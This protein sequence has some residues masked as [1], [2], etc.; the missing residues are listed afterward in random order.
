MGNWIETKDG[1]EQLASDYF[2]DLF[3]A[4]VPGDREEAFRY[5]TA[6]VTH[7][8]NISLTATPIEA[9]IKEAVFARNPEKAPGPDG[10]TSLFY[11][12]CWK[13]IGKDIIKTVQDFFASGELDERMNH[14]NICLIPK[15]DRPT[16][17]TEFRPSSLC[18]VSYKIISKV[19]SSRLKKVLP[20]L[21]SETQSAFSGS[22][23]DHRQHHGSSRDVPRSPQTRAAKINT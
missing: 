23:S 17:M 7:D 12:R 9:E 2:T 18:N 14:T 8:M 19:L 10:M 11:Q 4:S 3:R 15:T 20:D 6:S 22:T 5:I 1:L 21:I 13:V 16:S